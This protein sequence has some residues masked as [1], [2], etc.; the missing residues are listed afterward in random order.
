MCL[1][2]YFLIGESG[3]DESATFNGE[4]TSR[5]EHCFSHQS[6]GMSGVEMRVVGGGWWI[7]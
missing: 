7:G 5:T 1:T 6:E 3:A 4:K 2:I